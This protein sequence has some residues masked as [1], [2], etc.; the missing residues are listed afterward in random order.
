MKDVGND[1]Y[2]KGKTIVLVMGFMN[3]EPFIVIS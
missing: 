3:K 2:T 1:E